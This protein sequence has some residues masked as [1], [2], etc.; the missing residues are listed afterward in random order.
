VA[1]A[2]GGTWREYV[3]TNAAQALDCRQ[4][5]EELRGMSANISDEKIRFEL[6]DI[7]AQYNNSAKRAECRP[8]RLQAGMDI[9]AVPGS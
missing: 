8:P 4:K 2:L 9:A 5:A 7:A 6:W 1:A 3:L